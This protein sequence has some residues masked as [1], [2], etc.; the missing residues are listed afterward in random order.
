MSVPGNYFQIIKSG[1]PLFL[2]IL[3]TAVYVYF[4]RSFIRCEGSF[5]CVKMQGELMSQIDSPALK[6][7]EANQIIINANTNLNQRKTPLALKEKEAIEARDALL[8]TQKQISEANTNNANATVNTS[9]VNTTNSNAAPVAN[10]SDK[11]KQQT[12][13]LAY[14]LA[15]VKDM[16][17]DKD[18]AQNELIA[19]RKQ[20][21]ARYASRMMWVF[22][23]GVFMMLCA[24]TFVFS[25]YVMIE[26][27]ETWKDF[28]STRTI[29]LVATLIIAVVFALIAY[30]GE[31]G[32]MSIVKPIFAQ[33]IDANG[34][35]KTQTINL[36]N[37][38]G[39]AATIFLVCASC[40][41][42]YKI[43]K[44]AKTDDKVDDDEI[45]KKTRNKSQ[46]ILYV[47]AAMLFVGIMRIQTL[48]DWHLAFVSGTKDTGFYELLNNYFKASASVQ[49]SFYTLL[50]MVIYLPVAYWIWKHEKPKIDPLTN[51][52]VEENWS[53]TLGTYLPRL[54]TLLSPFM[55]KPIADL[56]SGYLGV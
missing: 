46:M 24:A 44:A 21:A 14:K 19:L 30:A 13:D 39:F 49:A 29:W 7:S 2:L 17:A 55:A 15:E 4:D 20:I 54:L 11:K 28:V 9:V 12:E 37:V 42:F 51:L 32:Y 3:L 56:L 25:S 10:L 43:E 16:T 26:P 41:I 40:S 34:D 50:L 53:A 31:D 27:V 36:F 35:L 22:L 48:A 38:I 18:K 8:S 45:I 1:V 33:S 47:G 6:L 5:E 52:P 23:T